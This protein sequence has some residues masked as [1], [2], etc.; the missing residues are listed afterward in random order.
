MIPKAE[1]VADGV[2]VY[3]Y[4]VKGQEYEK[5]DY[6]CPYCG[7]PLVPVDDKFWRVYP[8]EKHAN[9]YCKAMDE[10]E[11]RI[12]NPAITKEARFFLNDRRP[13][14]GYRTSGEG[15]FGAENEEQHEALP[16]LEEPEDDETVS[17][18][19]VGHIFHEG[20]RLATS[21]VH[22]TR[23]ETAVTRMSQLY[24]EKFHLSDL[25]TPMFAGKRGDYMVLSNNCDLFLNSHDNKIIGFKIIEVAF[26]GYSLR[27]RTLLFEIYQDEPQPNSKFPRPVL[28]ARAEMTC[29]DEDY[30]Q[31][32]LLYKHFVKRNKQTGKYE[33]LYKKVILWVRG[34]WRW[35]SAD[36]CKSCK[37]KERHLGAEC[38]ACRGLAK[39]KINTSAA[40]LF[41]R[42]QHNNGKWSN[43]GK[44]LEEEEKAL[45]EALEA[46]DKEGGEA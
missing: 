19:G 36:K 3:P 27:D 15:L 44:A 18:G 11:G 26:A 28:R 8:S 4:D 34:S 5:G 1:R 39:S 16:E 14:R 42:W 30:F 20:G 22:H 21:A 6:V 37:Y 13:E 33:Y 43:R 38:G 40:M 24:D 10:K 23:A 2:L 32:V 46:F 41:I 7:I 31:D 12:H 29:L 45:N 17:A 35:T 9:E 25:D